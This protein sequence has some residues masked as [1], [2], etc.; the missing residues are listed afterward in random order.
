VTHYL[1]VL[2]QA[3]LVAAVPKYSTR[4]LRRRASP[5]KLIVL[6]QAFLSA[7]GQGEPPTPE[8]DPMRWGNWVENACLAHAWNSG[9]EVTYWRE[10][11]LE[12]DAVLAG[13]WGQWAVEAKT[14]DYTVQDL[15][16]L[17][18]FCRRNGQFRPLVLCDSGTED[19]ARRAGVDALSWKDYLLS[20]P[21]GSTGDAGG[22]Q[23]GDGGF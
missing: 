12:V 8:T 6:N 14:G 15:S 2:E 20:G 7:V 4:E 10:E 1:Q 21:G 13:S 19:V 16:G 9:Q 11:P 23:R 5:P 17:T 22:E 3:Y 18:E